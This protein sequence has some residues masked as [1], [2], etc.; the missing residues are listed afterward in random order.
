MGKKYTQSFLVGI[1]KRR[2][3]LGRRIILI[4]HISN[5]K[6]EVWKGLIS[7]RTR[8]ITRLL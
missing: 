4:G 3:P 7:Q 1:P 8:I 6:G 2:G 5:R